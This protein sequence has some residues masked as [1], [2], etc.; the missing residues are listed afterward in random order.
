MNYML[1]NKVDMIMFTRKCS[2][3][4]FKDAIDMRAKIL[5]VEKSTPY[6]KRSNI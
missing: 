5:G 3:C 6:E 4:E 2:L 1:E